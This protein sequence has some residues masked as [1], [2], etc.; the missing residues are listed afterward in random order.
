MAASRQKTKGRLETVA[1]DDERSLSFVARGTGA[2]IVLLHGAVSTHRDWLDG[3]FEQLA[4][5]G[6]AISV[7]RPGH[8]A[9]RRARFDAEP[10][11]QARQ[12]HRGLQGLG[13]DRPI[14]VAHSLGGR[15]ALAYAEQFPDEVGGLVLV[16]PG[17]TPEMRVV[18]HFMLAPR[19]LPVAGPIMARLMT[20]SFDRPMLKV[21]H[22]LMFSPQ[23]PDEAWQSNYPWSDVLDPGASVA[24][25]E[26][27]AEFS[28]VGPVEL[29][30]L[31][32]IET[33][34]WVLAGGSDRILD[35][36]RHASALAAM[37][38]NARLKIVAGI[39]HMLH[40]AAT[41]D[42]IEAVESALALAD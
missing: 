5:M 14:I 25:A 27:F 37:L 10:R 23:S 19:A 22:P 38:P 26:E 1:I 11:A 8:G 41:P 12:I 2:D 36:V 33:P 28:M 39:G 34:T 24:E 16:A 18:E 40:R 32:R 42:L 3:P 29:L 17:F 6:R 30:D 13:L 15:V 4:R 35:P 7:D 9:S 31:R 20:S 21:L